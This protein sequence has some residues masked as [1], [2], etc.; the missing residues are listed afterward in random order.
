MSSRRDSERGT[1]L[2]EFALVLPLIMAL[3]LGLVTGGS[4]YNRK[5]SMTNAVREGS[6]FGAT[7]DGSTTWASS[8]QTRTVELA[9]GDLTTSQVC[10]QLVKNGSVVS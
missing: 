1:A 4:A 3:I 8:V 7:L 10:V 2:V 6:R 5:L 9:T